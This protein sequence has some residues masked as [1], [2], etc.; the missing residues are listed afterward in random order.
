[1]SSVDQGRTDA[2]EKTY[3]ERAYRLLREHI[4]AGRLEPGLK[5]KIDMLRKTYGL[6][7]GPLREALA[8]LSGDHL[9][10]LEGQRGCVVAPMSLQDALDIGQMRKLLE[11]QA[12][13]LSIPTGDEAWEDRL[14]AAFHRLERVEKR[15]DQGIDDLAEWE[16]RN[17]QFHE[18]LVSGC[19]SPWLLKMRAMMFEQHERYRRL[20]RLRTVKTR[21]IHEE[22]RALFDAAM[23]RDIDQAVAVIESHIEGTTAAVAA[24]F[25]RNDG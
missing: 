12:L 14:V 4:V 20:S 25:S 7:T 5:L 19:D 13:R 22:H 8:R 3:A 15:A 18:A 9:V 23:A 1:M 6:G 11:A 21:R 16:L 2:S 17:G 10:R 24:A